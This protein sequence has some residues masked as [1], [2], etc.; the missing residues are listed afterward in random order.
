MSSACCA[1][2]YREYMLQYKHYISTASCYLIVT[3]VQLID[4]NYTES[5]TVTSEN[6]QNPSWGNNNINEYDSAV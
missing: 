2:E 6:D 4:T 3:A 1:G 5:V